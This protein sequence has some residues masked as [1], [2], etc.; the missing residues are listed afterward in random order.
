M[1]A[2]FISTSK[3]F[4]LTFLAS[5]PLGETV[6]PEKDTS[7]LILFFFKHINQ[8]CDEVSKRPLNNYIF[9]WGNNFAQ[10]LQLFAYWVNH[11]YLRGR[12]L[13][14]NI[15][16]SADI[17]EWYTAA[18]VDH[19]TDHHNKTKVLGELG[20]VCLYLLRYRS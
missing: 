16:Q 3:Y 20:A 19:E 15:F 7:T 6:C 9:L 11:V 1:A 18:L 8:W 13:K 12:P 4:W 14:S 5:M 17:L 2:A 10:R